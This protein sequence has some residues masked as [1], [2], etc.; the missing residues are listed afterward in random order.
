M[1]VCV[2]VCLKPSY[3][4]GGNPQGDVNNKWS[5]RIARNVT[6]NIN[7]KNAFIITRYLMKGRLGIKR[8]CMEF[9]FP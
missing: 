3:C 9:I 8:T 4:S 5:F 2:C 7:M 1:C 6:W